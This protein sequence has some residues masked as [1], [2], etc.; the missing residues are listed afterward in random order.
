MPLAGDDARSRRPVARPPATCISGEIS[1]ARALRGLLLRP[2]R[3]SAGYVFRLSLRRGQVPLVL[4][5]HEAV[6]LGVLES[7]GEGVE[8]L[9]ARGMQAPV[10]IQGAPRPKLEATLSPVMK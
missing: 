8:L 9:P 7:L 10:A 6:G 4:V 1:R 2:A 3:S 5:L